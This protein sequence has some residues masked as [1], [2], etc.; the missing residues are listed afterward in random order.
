MQQKV[1]LLDASKKNAIYLKDLRYLSQKQEKLKKLVCKRTANMTVHKIQV[2]EMN[3]KSF[4]DVALACISSN[5]FL[6]L[7]LAFDSN[8]N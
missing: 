2:A 6:P 7:F 8:S 4:K 5:Y 3:G 1:T